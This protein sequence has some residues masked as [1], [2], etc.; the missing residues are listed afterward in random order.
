[1]DHV[2]LTDQKAELTHITILR[3]HWSLVETDETVL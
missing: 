1:M 2:V 3:E